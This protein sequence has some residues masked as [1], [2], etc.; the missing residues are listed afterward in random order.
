MSI[1]LGLLST[2]VIVMIAVARDTTIHDAES[3]VS[4]LNGTAEYIGSI[5]RMKLS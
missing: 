5:P 4:H 2:C 3:L 1:V